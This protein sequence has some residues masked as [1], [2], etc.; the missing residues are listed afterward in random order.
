[1]FQN[2]HYLFCFKM[3][4]V[5]VL[6]APLG[7]C[8]DTDEAEAWDTVSVGFL[9]QTVGGDKKNNRLKIDAPQGISFKATLLSEGDWCSF[10]AREKQLTREGVTPCDLFVYFDM[11][12]QPSERT[13]VVRVELANSKTIEARFTQEAYTAQSK[14]NR[15]WGEQPE[16]KEHPDYIYKTYFTDLVNGK[17]VRNYSVCYDTRR[18]VSHWVAYPLHNCYVK[19]SVERTDAWAYDPN[20]QAPA[21]PQSQQQYI[22]ES[23]KSGYVRGHQIPSADRYNSVKTNQMTFYATN[24]MPQDYDFNGGAWASLE[25]KV[26]SN[27]VSDTLFVVTGTYF[28]DS[29]T[30][31]DR[32]GNVIA[33]PSHCWKVLLRTR[34]GNTGKAVADCSAEELQ[35]I[36]FWFENKDKY[37]ANTSL[38]EHALSVAEIEKRTGFGFFR[39]LDEKTARTVKSQN[40]PSAWQ[41]H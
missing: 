5:F 37:N 33:V 15:Q 28:G 9:H 39:E 20:D 16:M 18:R 40:N 27:I 10:A 8:S 23:Y 41:I 14:Y 36:G 29:R 19:P 35:A 4:L 3:L 13:V 21:I 12:R 30:M 34:K 6:L 22:I 38:K 31:R 11:N 25:S 1:M 32:K 7:A 26:R 24:M 17:H 2:R